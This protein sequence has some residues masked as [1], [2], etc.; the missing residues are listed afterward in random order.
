MTMVIPVSS[1]KYPTDEQSL[2]VFQKLLEEVR[3]LPGVNHAAISSTVPF[4]RG[5]ADGHIIE[6]KSQRA[7]T[8]HRRRSG[9]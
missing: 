3:V 2:A 1:K 6:G 7:A 5:A 4:T 8:L 9:S